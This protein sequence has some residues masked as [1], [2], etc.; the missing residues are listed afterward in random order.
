MIVNDI[1]N[2]EISE[3]LNIKEMKKETDNRYKQKN[4]EIGE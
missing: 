1:N 4:R 2:S 3:S